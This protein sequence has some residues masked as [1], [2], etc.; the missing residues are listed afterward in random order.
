MRIVT[1]KEQKIVGIVDGT[2]IPIPAE[3]IAIEWE[4]PEEPETVIMST[5]LEKFTEQSWMTQT[6]TTLQKMTK[7][8]VCLLTISPEEFSSLTGQPYPEYFR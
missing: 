8:P 5:I 1:K 2:A 7:C 4:A 3:E 6:V